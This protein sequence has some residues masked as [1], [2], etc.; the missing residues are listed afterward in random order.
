MKRLFILLV[1]AAIAVGGYYYLAPGSSAQT[2]SAGSAPALPVPVVVAEATRK[3]MPVELSTIGRVQTVASVAV[4]SRIDGVITGVNV[5]DGQEVKAGE[6]LFTLDDRALQAAL[7][8]TQ[9]ALARDKAQLDN[10]K[11]DV[12]RIAPLAQRDFVSR[13]ALDQ[14]RT[15][16]AALEATVQSD[17]AQVE[18]AQVQLSYT[19]IRA[20]FAGR[21]GTISFK[22]G[23]SIKANDTTSL[24]TLNQIRPIYV[25]FSLP[26]TNFAAIQ[27][28]MAKHA[29][30]VDASVP[31]DPAAPLSGQV[32]YIENLIDPT[33]NTLSVKAS[34]G[35]ADNRL[36]P[37][38]FVNV[39]MTLGVQ[40]DA[41]V[42]PAEAVQAGQNTSFVYVVKE[43]STVEARPVTI[44]RTV[45]AETVIATGVAAGDKVVV[46]GQLRLD[47]GTKVEIRP[48]DNG[49]APAHEGRVS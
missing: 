46:N 28:A 9:A 30:G 17:Q 47:N 27:Q 5:A 24:V 35:N 36:W 13:Q 37:G 16:V 49:P 39:T 2:K 26:Q 40:P 23:N 48:A 42:V 34:F 19:A 1:A 45:G 41:V 31:G 18:A 12:D 7:H 8:Q 21:L 14:A 6:I 4:R 20:P 33:T 3:A 32:A 25:S 29:L 11:R 22:I 15:N 44:D 10:A 38:Q 43:D